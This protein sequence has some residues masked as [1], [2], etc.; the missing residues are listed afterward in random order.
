MRYRYDPDRNLIATTD[1]NGNTTSYTYDLANEQTQV[2]RAD[3]T[4]VRTGYDA[5]GNKTSLVDGAGDT[6][7]YGYDALN[8]LT[9]SVDPL[10]RVTSYGY[11]SAGNRTRVTNSSGEATSYTYDAANEP[12]AISYADGQTPNVTRITYDAD[13]Q[14][15][16]MTDGTGTSRWEW[17]SLHRLTESVDGSGAVVRYQYDLA[18]ELTSLTYPN[19]E[20]VSRSYDAAGRLRSFTDWLGNTTTFSYDPDSELTS[21]TLPSSTQV[22]DRFAYDG[23]DRLVRI[24]DLRDHRKLARFNYR[25][26]S[27]S[28]VISS[29]SPGMPHGNESYTYTALNQTAS[30]SGGNFTYDSAD[31]LTRNEDTYQSFDTGNQLCWA[32]SSAGTACGQPPTGATVYQYNAQGDRTKATPA[33]DAPTTYGWDQ[34]DR[35]TSLSSATRTASYKYDGDGLRTSKT[36]NGATQHFTWDHASSLPLLLAD[37]QN[38]YIY[39]PG[40]AVVEQ[41]TGH[42]PSWLH[43]DQLG[44]VRLITNGSGN[45]SGTATYSPY[46]MLL[47]TSGTAT[48]PFRFAGQYTDAES[49]LQY[50]QARYYDASTAQFLSADPL[51]AT[52]RARYAYGQDNPV[53][54]SDPIGLDALSVSCDAIGGGIDD[55]PH[56]VP[57]CLAVQSLEIDRQTIMSLYYDTQDVYSELTQLETYSA[58]G[59]AEITDLEG[60]VQG[61]LTSLSQLYTQVA[62]RENQLGGQLNAICAN[63]GCHDHSILAAAGY[64]FTQCV[65]GGG[66]S[67]TGAAG[68][69]ATGTYLGIKTGQT[70]KTAAGFS[71]LGFLGGVD[72]CGAFIA[73]SAVLQGGY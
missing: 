2:G 54:K 18:G 8:R 70:L 46:G 17:D 6:T 34:A 55:D 56:A 49:G 38:S 52:T 14:R 44:S 67:A 9:R 30:A 66:P 57:L 60:N 73:G 65:A 68:G 71:V 4:I 25:R 69:L 7:S 41:I 27:N 5:A 61:R 12:T 20:T 72:A 42:S 29:K 1:A 59:Q 50:L 21:E 48:S 23:A 22:V 36:V 40:G 15:T 32:G 10:G 53:N 47:R 11:D 39:G 33:S 3:G 62:D 26:D 24:A 35:L 37:G 13:G 64:F 45:V 16:S 58:C 43:H 19:G 31:N 28:Q 63:G 51:A